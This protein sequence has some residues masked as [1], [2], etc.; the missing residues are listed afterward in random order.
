MTDVHLHRYHKKM[1]VHFLAAPRPRL[2]VPSI[3]W[4][5]VAVYVAGAFWDGRWHQTHPGMFESVS[6]M[7]HAHFGYGLGIT[8]VLGSALVI[9]RRTP[10]GLRRLSAMTAALASSASFIGTAWDSYLHAAGGNV[11]PAHVLNWVGLLIA[12][13]AIIMFT[14]LGERPDAARTA[15]A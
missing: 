10:P 5:G 14:L 9:I 13:A 7:A 6:Q 8:L 4:L 12:L 2:G 3:M 1:K 11:V 15:D